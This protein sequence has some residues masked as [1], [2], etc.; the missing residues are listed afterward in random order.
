V[1]SAYYNQGGDHDSMQGENG[2]WA[3]GSA[4]Y[5]GPENHTAGPETGLG[6]FDGGTGYLMAPP[7]SVGPGSH[8][9]SA[10]AYYPDPTAY[11]REPAPY[12]P[13]PFHRPVLE[14]PQGVWSPGPHAAGDP[15]ASPYTYGH[16]RGMGYPDDHRGIPAL[17]GP[18]SLAGWEPSE[19]GGGASHHLPVGGT[20]RDWLG[21]EALGHGVSEGGQGA[22]PSCSP[23]PTRAW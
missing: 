13:S 2:H 21:E 12:H 20:E 23:A 5:R 15:M 4:T 1:P 10:S 9:P 3:H 11:F 8:R 14:P 19:G 7:Q 17:P 22:G 18:G 6:G 16:G